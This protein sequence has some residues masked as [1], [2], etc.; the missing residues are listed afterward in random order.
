MIG[1]TSAGLDD[2]HANLN[3]AEDINNLRQY[4]K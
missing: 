2:T 4:I 3:F 1:I